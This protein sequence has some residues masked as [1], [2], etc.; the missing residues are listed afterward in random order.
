MEGEPQ[1]VSHVNASSS[2]ANKPI[3]TQSRFPIDPVKECMDEFKLSVKKVESQGFS[4][5]D[6]VGWISIAETYIEVH[7]ID[8]DMKIKLTRLC[9]EGNTIHWFNMWRE[10]KDTPTWDGLKRTLM[11]W[12]GATR[13]E[14]LFEALKVLQQQGFVDEYLEAFEFIS[15]QAPK[16]TK[17]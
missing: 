4:G 9:M 2:I 16:L 12:Y 5:I 13:Y 17:Q 1:S 8:D 14:N 3:E 11:L 15:S 7:S 6:P 10:S